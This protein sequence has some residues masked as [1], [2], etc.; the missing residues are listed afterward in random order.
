MNPEL[1]VEEIIVHSDN[2]LPPPTTPLHSL[3][4]SFNG[5]Y[6]D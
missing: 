6:P 5:E 2:L 4:S 3:P 1:N